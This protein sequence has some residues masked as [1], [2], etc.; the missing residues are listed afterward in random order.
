MS[1]NGERPAGASVAAS[2]PAPSLLCLAH[3]P[4]ARALAKAALPRR[5][6]RVLT[7]RTVEEFEAA[8]RT[9][10]IDAAIV[11]AGVTG[12]ETWRAIGLSAEFPSVP[13]FAVLPLRTTDGPALGRCAE[14]EL[15]D[16]L[17]E[18]VDDAVAPAIVAPHLFSTR[19]EFAM[20]EPPPSLALA[21]TVQREAWR[22]IVAHAGRPVRTTALAGTMGMTREHL[23]RTFAAKGAPNLKRVID[24][25]RLIAAAELAKNP[26]YDIRDVAHVLG[27]A[28]SSHLSSCAQRLVGTRPTS[29]SR[30][31]T[32]DL[33]ERF[34]HGRGRSRA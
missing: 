24:L 23:S 32:A 10:V 12:E 20:R 16:V 30:L 17:V 3:R 26:G 29:L 2:P 27:F 5:R 34:A 6:G 28:S 13:F 14:H 4:R 19:F 22:R 25:V 15:A 8:F 18:G 9:T 11:D 33:L 21:S 1:R 7:A 31:R